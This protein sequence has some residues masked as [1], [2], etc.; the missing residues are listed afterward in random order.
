MNTAK[1]LGKCLMALLLAAVLILPMGGLYYLSL[2]EQAQYDTIYEAG[3]VVLEE[4]SYGT[5]CLVIRMD[6]TEEVSLSG[7]VV[8][9][10]VL[11]EELNLDAPDDLR[12]VISEGEL[13]EAGGLIGYYHGKELLSTQTGVVRTVHLGSESYIALWSLED[14]AVECYVSDAQ[15]SV[16]NRSTLDLTDSEGNHYTVSHIDSEKVGADETRVL[17]TSETATLI[18]NTGFNENMGTGRVYPGSLVV[19]TDCIFTLEGQSY[20]RLVEEDGSIIGLA[21][22]EV[23]VTVG[24][25]TSISGINEGDY[26]DPG[27][28]AMVG[29]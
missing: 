18:Y 10:K 5:P 24:S 21:Q 15:L 27:Y 9:T 2:L 8:S 6:L 23:G 16:L 12:L 25:Y 1:V 7:A 4:V 11:Y 20:V 26:C 14:L 19:P 3:S 28:K 13:L 22:V 29:G 17:L